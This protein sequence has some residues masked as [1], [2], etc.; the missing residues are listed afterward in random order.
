[1]SG[2]YADLAREVD[3]ER[4]KSA[5]H[6]RLVRQAKAQRPKRRLLPVAMPRPRPAPAIER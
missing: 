4:L 5:A 2:W 6:Q 3:R 1:M